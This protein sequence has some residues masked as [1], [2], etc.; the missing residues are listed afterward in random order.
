[1]FWT[2]LL[3]LTTNIKPLPLHKLKPAAGLLL[4]VE[5]VRVSNGPEKNKNKKNQDAMALVNTFFIAQLDASVGNLKKK[6]TNAVKR[7]IF[8]NSTI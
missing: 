4:V 2:A 1:M 6:C 3:I 8:L 7:W 5:E